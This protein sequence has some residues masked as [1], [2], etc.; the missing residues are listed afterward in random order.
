MEVCG[1]KSALPLCVWKPAFVKS[2]HI[3]NPFS[4]VVNNQSE[5]FNVVLKHLQHW[6]KVPVNILVTIF[7][8]TL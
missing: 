4:A 8:V 6:K 2:S 3:Y 5:I 1:E 7:N